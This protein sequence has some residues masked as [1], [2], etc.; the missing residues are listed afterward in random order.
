MK[1][2]L[3]KWRRFI[4]QAKGEPLHEQEIRLP[5]EE[6]P[7]SANEPVV[8]RPPKYRKDRGEAKRV[9]K[10]VTKY[11]EGLYN[12]NIKPIEDWYESLSEL[13]M[14]FVDLVDP[15][16]ITEHPSWKEAYAEYSEWVK[17]P[18]GHPGKD[19]I[20]GSSLFLNYVIATILAVPGLDIV[21]AGIFAA[22]GT[23]SSFFASAV[24]FARLAAFIVKALV[25]LGAAWT[26]HKLWVYAEGQPVQL[27]RGLEYYTGSEVAGPGS[28]RVMTKEK[29]DL[30]FGVQPTAS[31]GGESGLEMDDRY[32]K[33]YQDMR[34]DINLIMQFEK[35]FLKAEQI[36]AGW[37]KAKQ[38]SSTRIT[39]TTGEDE[40]QAIIRWYQRIKAKEQRKSRET[41][42]PVDA[43]RGGARTQN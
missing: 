21:P 15:L 7:P 16:G 18:I 10:S 6:G 27:G 19:P 25:V 31:R 12:S 5:G 41:K 40:K 20:T 32:K 2:V 33:T 8:L 13:E 35:E 30:T 28:P 9:P 29:A 22:T 39:G 11:I 26:I 34:K 36:R 14:L 24:V 38:A 37:D 42:P 23:K 17:L 4:E 43:P 1:E 3:D